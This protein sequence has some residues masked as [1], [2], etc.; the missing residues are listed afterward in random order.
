M[1]RFALEGTDLRRSVTILALG[2]LAL[3][4]VVAGP[5]DLVPGA[6]AQSSSQAALDRYLLAR[7]AFEATARGYWNEVSEKRRIRTEK[8]RRGQA[9]GL[10]DYVLAQPP[11]YDG[12]S[13]PPSAVPPSRDPEPSRPSIPVIADFLAAAQAEFGFVPDRP[14]NEL[15]FKR[16]YAQA[17]REAGLTREQIVGIYAFETGGNGTHDLQAGLLHNRPGARAIS[18][19]IGYNQLLS[20]T[21]IGLLAEHGDRFVATLRREAQ[22]LSG[23][24]RAAMLRKAD[25]LQRMVAFTRSVPFAWS[26]HDDLSKTR[27]GMGVHAAVLDRDIGP[28]LQ[29]QN[30]RT[31]VGFA[32]TRGVKRTL[33]AAEL[34]MMNFTGA[35]NGIDLVMMPN[36]LR[37]KVPTSNF[38]QR[39]GYERN[40]I[41]QRTATVDNLY[42][43]IETRIGRASQNAG[44]RA[45]A[46]A[47]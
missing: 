46:S 2:C 3:A 36:S 11:V 41:A 26:A 17:A 6:H 8:R 19:A 21:T 35:G 32:R 27:P 34:Q 28:M 42:E 39:S 16:A 15:E 31:S 9:V 45:M 4:G 5:P 22:S 1:G 30:L 14:R 10:R 18:A 13:R 23:G 24:D 47:Y 29:V 44:A 25:I 40:P 38:F 43:A 20:T 33:T 7:R 37:P 12:P